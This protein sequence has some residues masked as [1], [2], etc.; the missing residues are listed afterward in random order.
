MLGKWPIP[1][2]LP[3]KVAPAGGLWI[4]RVLVRAQEGQYGRRKRGRFYFGL[5]ARRPAPKL[6]GCH[7]PSDDNWGARINS[8]AEK[9]PAVAVVNGKLYLAGGLNA[10]V[11]SSDAS[12]YDPVKGQWTSLPPMSVAR[13][14]ATA[15]GLNGL[16]YVIAGLDAFGPVTTE[17][18]NP[19]TN[20]WRTV[21]GM[22]T[23]RWSPGAGA[24]NGK[25]YAVG[26]NG[27]ITLQTTEVYTP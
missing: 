16:L 3:G 17:V 25:L 5:V 9:F 26:G 24:I 7:A 14:A 13:Y 15:V 11:V 6:T 2:K 20:T 21:T 22:P 18:Y 23:A 12:V 10:G 19:A 8:P 4:R 27:G 1:N